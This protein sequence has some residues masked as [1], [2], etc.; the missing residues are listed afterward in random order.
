MRLVNRL[1]VQLRRLG[2]RTEIAWTPESRTAMVSHASRDGLCR[3]LV[4][5]GG[6]GTISA[7]L[8]ERPTTPITVLPAGTENLVA[9]HFGLLP[10]PGSLAQTIAAGRLAAVD[11]GQAAHRR[12]LLMVGFGFDADVVTRHHQGRITRSGSVRPT[13]RMAY[14]EPILRS[15]LSY[16]FAP[17]S[18]RIDEHKTA[19]VLR[20]TTVLV[21]NLPRYALGLPFA[22]IAREDDGWL[23]LVVFRD[24]GPFQA[25]HYIW[26]VFRGVHL[27]DPG[28]FHRRVRKIAVTADDPIPVQIDGDPGGYLLPHGSDMPAHHRQYRQGCPAELEPC[29][30]TA[31][32]A[33]WTVEI[34]PAAIQVLAPAGRGGQRVRSAVASNGV[35]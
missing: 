4:A 5:V 6:D 10:D 23:D 29:S 9:R 31:N 17:I 33:E 11:I 25:L 35:A 16:P 28:V 18:V 34:L 22:P 2:L 26:K 13:H 21:F 8:N 12:F 32:P 7:L 19:E 14:V 24:P 3:C 27:H 30:P 20:G 15:S 1:V